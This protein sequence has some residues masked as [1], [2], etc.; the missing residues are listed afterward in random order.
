MTREHLYVAA[1]RARDTTTLYVATH[2]VLPV[3]QDERVDRARW[4]PAARTAREVPHE[5]L[6]REGAE[7]S[8]TEAIRETATSE[9]ASSFESAAQVAIMLVIGLAGGAGSFTHIHDVAEAQGQA[10]WLAWADA[11]VLELM[12]IA[13]GLE[14][15]RRKPA[16]M[17]DRR[18]RA[19][20]DA[21]RA[22]R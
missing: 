8:A 21:C 16:G 4:D 5:I 17:P 10:G 13:S 2:D 12:S 18:G 11:V 1:T 20:R 19:R 3:D 22:P 6:G 15:R 9:R 14:L 7:L